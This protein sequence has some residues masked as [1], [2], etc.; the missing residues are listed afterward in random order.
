MHA[1]IHSA[2]V[3]LRRTSLAVLVFIFAIT[4]AP[5][6]AGARPA[7]PYGGF[8]GACGSHLTEL[9][10]MCLEFKNAANEMVGFLL[11]WTE[12]GRPMSPNL[13]GRAECRDGDAQFYYCTALQKWFSGNSRIDGTG[14]SRWIRDSEYFEGFRVT[15]LAYDSEYCFR[16]RA[17]D[18]S[19]VPSASWSGW[20]CARTRPQPPSP[21]APPTPQVTAMAATSGKGEVG[22]GTPF[23]V[24]VEWEPPVNEHLLVGSYTIELKREQGWVVITHVRTSSGNE[25]FVEFPNGSN[26][27]ESYMFRVCSQNIVDTACSPVARTSG[28]WWDKAQARSTGSVFNNQSKDMGTDKAEE[29]PAIETA[30]SVRTLETNTSVKDSSDSS[31][32]SDTVAVHKGLP[33][34]DKTSNLEIQNAM[35]DLNN[36][37]TSK[38]SLEKKAAETISDEGR[39]PGA[40]KNQSTVKPGGRVVV[41]GTAPS[42]PSM[43]ICEAARAARARNNPAA[44]GLEAQCRAVGEAPAAADLDA[45]AEKGESIAGQDPL[46]VELREQ[47][48]EG[49][50]RRG[51]DIGMATAEGQTEPGPGKDRLRDSLPADERAGFIAAVA[52]SLE[53]NKNAERAALGARI[54]AADPTVAEARNAE[55]D[56]FYRLGFDIAT[57]IFGDPAQGAQGNTQAGPGSLGLRDSL[58]AAGQ[59]GFNAAVKFHLGRRY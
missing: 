12:N 2:R 59:R 1:Q 22:P 21:G 46:A 51:F 35:S 17:V 10:K 23:R 40:S 20:T 24:L 29:K 52:F 9:P 44:A 56:P 32:A 28:R 38:E 37:R 58:S 13:S 50:A 47:Q 36:A 57:A 45:L 33:G 34:E 30:G 7:R 8:A 19:G 39:K 16:F 14:S 15:K 42:G 55:A 5:S 27:D 26:Q 4:L 31:V 53:R 11:E 25:G 43:T 3:A 54:A 18:S 48:P 49:G 6:E 41:G